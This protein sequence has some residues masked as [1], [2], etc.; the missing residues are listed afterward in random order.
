MRIV[1][2][3][4]QGED[5]AMVKEVVEKHHS[6]LLEVGATIT[7][8]MVRAVRKSGRIL[9]RHALMCRGAPAAATVR[10]ASPGDRKNGWGDVV[11]RL[12]EYNW[13][14]ELDCLEKAAL[15]DHELCHISVR[16]D[17]NGNIRLT[18]EG[19]PELKLVP[20][21]AESGVF[22]DVVRRHGRKAYDYFGVAHLF[23]LVR[24][25]VSMGKLA[26]ESDNSQFALQSCSDETP[27]LSS[28]HIAGK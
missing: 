16:K 7:V 23:S 20:H 27:S 2:E 11:I 28:I 3:I 18:P 14:E 25:E 17:R 1:V 9:E 15:L 10:V 6:H 26:R 21:D 5:E 24:H 13:K 22:L 12:D 8:L 19:R 4:A